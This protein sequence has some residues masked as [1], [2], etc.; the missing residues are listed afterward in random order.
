MTHIAADT[1]LEAMSGLVAPVVPV[2][3]GPIG[4]SS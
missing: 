2:L 3:T 4:G 1:R